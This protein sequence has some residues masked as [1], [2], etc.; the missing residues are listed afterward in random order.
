MRP[1]SRADVRARQGNE[2]GLAEGGQEGQG[3]A[4]ADD[5]ASD[6]LRRS[7]NFIARGQKS[8][9]RPAIMK[10]CFSTMSSLKSAWLGRFLMHAFVTPRHAW[11]PGRPRGKR[12]RQALTPGLR[13]P[14][15]AP[16]LFNPGVYLSPIAAF[17]QGDRSMTTWP[18]HGRISGPIVM[19]GFGSIGQGTLP[20]IERHFDFD[21]SR[22]VVI[23]PQDD[24]DRSLLDERGIRFIQQAVTRDN[25]R[26][27]SRRF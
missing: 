16:N 14:R 9:R 10:P 11:K 2:E 22:F 4:E 5:R 25:Y 1:K 24:S 15:C 17:R 26:E 12:F 23:D 13:N 19:I 6:R 20:L 18:V 27:L 7:W 3:E 8:K 21:K